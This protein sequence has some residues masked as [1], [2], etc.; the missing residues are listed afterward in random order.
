MATGC[1]GGFHLRG[2]AANESAAGGSLFGRDVANAY[3]KIGAQG[4]AARAM[5]TAFAVRNGT[6]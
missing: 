5:A 6:A 2:H 1:T 3:N 4:R